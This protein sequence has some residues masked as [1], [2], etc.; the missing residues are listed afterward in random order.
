MTK[1][2]KA[3][4]ALYLETAPRKSLCMH[5]EWNSVK[6]GIVSRK[7]AHRS[8]IS[9]ISFPSYLQRLWKSLNLRSLWEWFSHGGQNSCPPCLALAGMSILSMPLVLWGFENILCLWHGESD[10]F[11][12]VISK[13]WWPG[14][15]CTFSSVPFSLTPSKSGRSVTV[16][17]GCLLAHMLNV[18]GFFLLQYVESIFCLKTI[19]DWN[20]SLNPLIL[21]IKVTKSQLLIGKD[22]QRHKE[23]NIKSS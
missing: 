7:N 6:K 18:M 23:K 2:Q 13:S 20:S 8:T 15:G 21:K 11:Q 16:C 12:T 1:Q 4:L 19:R 5:A 3:I 10:V 14:Q 22:I 17:C 9:G